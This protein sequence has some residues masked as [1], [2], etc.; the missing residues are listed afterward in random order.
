MYNSMLNLGELLFHSTDWENKN[1]EGQEAREVIFKIIETYLSWDLDNMSESEV[2]R[3]AKFSG[4]G[5]LLSREE[6]SGDRRMHSSLSDC[7]GRRQDKR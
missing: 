7:L 3:W 1:P 6:R 5:G 4:G 2:R